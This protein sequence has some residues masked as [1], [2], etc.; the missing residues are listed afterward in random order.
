MSLFVTKQ[1]RSIIVV[2]AVLISVLLTDTM[3]NQVSDFLAR[4]LTSNF[5]LI[6]FIVFG[7]ILGMSQFF[8]LKY[9]KQ[10]ISSLYSGSP[11][12]KYLHSIVT[13]MQY[14]LLGIIT[15]LI[16]QTVFD[17]FYFTYFLIA[18]TAISE[19]LSE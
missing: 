1:D 11:P 12:A 7:A 13:I 3:I 10:K 18:I 6:T 16:I 2:M 9:V 8:I 15:A 14:L 19:I 17:S 4:Q 5:G